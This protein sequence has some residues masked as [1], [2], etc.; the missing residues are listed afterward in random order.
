MKTNVLSKKIDFKSGVSLT[1]FRNAEGRCSF[2]R[3]TRP[4]M[5][6]SKSTNSSIN[7]GMACHIYSASLG[8]PRGRGGHAADFIESAANGIWCCT[9]HGT[10]IDK[11]QGKD[12]PA[13]TLFAWK[14]LAE[15]RTR[16][17]MDDMPSPLGWVESIAYSEFA[18]FAIPPSATLSRNTLLCGTN[19]SGKTALLEL[20][21]SVSNS[22]YAW[23]FSSNSLSVVGSDKPH[24]IF[25]GNL[26]YSTVD[27]HDKVVEILVQG[28][29]IKRME[30]KVAALLPPGDIEV[31]H[32][33]SRD[34]ELLEKG[35][36]IEMLMIALNVDKSTM[37][38][39][40]QA[41]SSGLLPGEIKL[42][43]GVEQGACHERTYELHFK[44]KSKEFF[45]PFRRL[46]SSEK[47]KLLTDLLISKAREI[48]KQRLTLLLVDSAMSTLDSENFER[49]L[50]VL[51]AEQ[52]QS[53]VVVSAVVA[54]KI[55]FLQDD[56]SA[57]L[58]QF[59]YLEP[60]RLAYLPPPRRSTTGS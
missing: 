18:G 8:G 60:W 38:A 29:H 7:M 25:R 57:M 31:L 1:L 6:P 19:S 45:I 50:R 23:R 22:R 28:D 42:T 52:F 5:G 39:L 27:T 10:L 20:A 46:S 14:R 51:A 30:G 35:D 2:P 40:V 26:R 49:L 32:V 17:R 44:Q 16:K 24:P 13:E 41:G 54:E 34:I 48:A 36:H 4:A 37:L 12:F 59:E 53:I 43:L 47:M 21:A 3:C 55:I 58:S 33:S 9:H 56:G 11:M 15:A